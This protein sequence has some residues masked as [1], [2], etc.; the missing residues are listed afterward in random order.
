MKAMLLAAGRGERMGELTRH[1]PKP[2]LDIGGERLI[3]RQLRLLA[4]AGFDEVVIN[5]SYRGDAIRAFIGSTSQWGQ[6]IAYSEEGEPALETGGGII[7]ALPLLGSAPFIAVN[8]D[9]VTD[10]DYSVLRRKRV[11]ALLV[12]VPNPAHHPHGDFGLT[13]SGLVTLEPPL[14]TFSGISVLSPE[15]F[16]GIA[17]GRQRL[18][19]ILESAIAQRRVAG[20]RHEGLWHDIGTPERL[21]EARHVVGTPGR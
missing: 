14:M 9:V 15:L 11:E 6:S 16:H 3:E 20:V 8:A 17:P 7:A 13:A 5:L 12:L 4:G 21:A 18:R 19:P 10:F 2:L 1:E